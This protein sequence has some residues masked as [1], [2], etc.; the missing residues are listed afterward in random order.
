M[1]FAAGLFSFLSPCV[2]PL[3]PSWLCLAGNTGPG[4]ALS[5][6]ARRLVPGTLSFI[7]G[8]SAVFV[9]FGALFSG[10]LLLL[11]GQ[12]RIINAIAGLIVIILGLNICFN[13]L[14]FLNYE[15]RFHPGELRGLGG[16][17]LAGAAFGAGWTPCVGPILGSVFILAGQS[18]KIGG[19]ILCLCAYSAG[20]GLPFLGAALALEPFLKRAARLRPLL[21]RIR[22]ISG[23]FL[24]AMGL[25]IFLNR[26]Q[27]LNILFTRGE[28]AFIDWAQGG[29]P[30]AR[31][32]PAALFF[33]IAAL[34]PL[35]RIPRAKP[36]FTRFS[37]V[38]FVLFCALGA[39]QIGG[40][41]DLAGLLA[42]GLLLR[43]GI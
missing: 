3:I 14:P 17:F 2:F 1:A 35:C 23:L 4:G 30:M 31:L 6:G 26:F 33:L 13:F 16:T 9:I 19:A 12:G 21:P 25:L 39:L 41:L 18:G 5:G 22:W 34:I 40:T 24:T 43:Q 32:I 7:A 36:P 29:G 27:S 42:R 37:A 38:F 10:S 11:G 8:F 15:R 20:L 28:Y